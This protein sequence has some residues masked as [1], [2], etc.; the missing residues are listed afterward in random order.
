MTS[1]PKQCQ[2]SD[3]LETK[4]IIYHSKG[5]DESC[6]KIYFLLNLSHYVKSYGHFCQICFFFTMTAH[7]IWSCHVTQKENFENLLSCPN[8]TFNI[9]KSHRISSGKALY[10]RSYQPKPSQGEHPLPS[11]FRVKCQ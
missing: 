9:R 2:N 8:S 1:F 10:F 4:Q 5:I 6:P 3:L 7:Q 11:A